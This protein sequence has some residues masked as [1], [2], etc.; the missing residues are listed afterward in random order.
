MLLGRQS[1]PHPCDPT[2]T[3]TS[4]PQPKRLDPL[5]PTVSRPT[6]ILTPELS[7][8]TPIL[9]VVPDRPSPIPLIESYGS[10][11]RAEIRRR[12]R[13]IPQG[14]PERNPRGIQ[15]ESSR[16]SRGKPQR[17]QRETPGG[18]RGL[19]DTVVG[20]IHRAQRSG[21][22]DLRKQSPPVFVSEP[23]NASVPKIGTPDEVTGSVPGSG[24]W[25]QTLVLP[26]GSDLVSAA[27][28]GFSSD[29]WTR[30]RERL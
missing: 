16:G 14:D 18:L 12:H 6:S 30:P 4:R 8:P 20:Q 9:H 29:P 11:Q 26:P 3:C 2:R 10:A 27:G 1:R 15:R 19:R 7:A 24:P 28:P 25:I 22:F 23:V 13:G 21:P 5:E 17:I